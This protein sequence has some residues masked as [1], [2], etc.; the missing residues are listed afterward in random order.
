MSHSH[1][2]RKTAT[3]AAV[4]IV[5]RIRIALMNLQ[6]KLREIIEDAVRD[7]SDMEMVD[8]D[9]QSAPRIEALAV[10]VAIVGTSDPDDLQLPARLLSE[11]PRLRVL[12]IA[13]SGR[14]AALYELRPQRT[15]LGEMSAPELMRA[16]RASVAS[17]YATP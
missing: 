4:V 8:A 15:T 14:A 5:N 13:T 1:S 11:T 12:M 2:L 7:A 17:R 6:P 10:D 16:I 3:I 9:V